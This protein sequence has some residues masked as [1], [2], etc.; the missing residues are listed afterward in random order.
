MGNYDFI[1]RQM[2]AGEPLNVKSDHEQ[3]VYTLVFLLNGNNNIWYES[4][5]KN[6]STST[7]FMGSTS[8]SYHNVKLEK[9]NFFKDPK[10]Y[11]LVIIN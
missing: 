2:H 8:F 11:I 9:Q 6:P 7:N 1:S 3:L 5:R 4:S 10:G